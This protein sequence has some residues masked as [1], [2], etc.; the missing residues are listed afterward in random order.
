MIDFDKIV[1]SYWGTYVSYV[2][3]FIHDENIK[4]YT[5][6]F[7]VGCLGLFIVVKLLQKLYTQHII[8]RWDP[9]RLVE[10][11]CFFCHFYNKIPYVND[12]QWVCFQCQQYNGFDKS[13]GDYNAVSPLMYQAVQSSGTNGNRG[14]LSP[15]KYKPFSGNH[16]NGTQSEESTQLCSKCLFH[17]QL[18][19]KRL[20]EFEPTKDKDSEYK[21]FINQVEKEFQLCNECNEKTQAEINRKDRYIISSLLNNNSNTNS[22]SNSFIRNSNSSKNNNFIQK[23]LGQLFLSIDYPKLISFLNIIITFILIVLITTS[24]IKIGITIDNNSKDQES[25]TR[26]KNNNSDDKQDTLQH[27]EIISNLLF[28]ILNIQQNETIVLVTLFILKLFYMFYKYNQEILMFKTILKHPKGTISR[29]SIIFNLL[30]VF[31]LAQIQYPSINLQLF[32]LSNIWNHF[33]TNNVFTF[34]FYLMLLIIQR[35]DTGFKG[36]QAVFTNNIT[37]KSSNNESNNSNQNNNNNN[38]NSNNSNVI[39]HKEFF[40]SM[41][42][43]ESTSTSTSSPK[44]TPIKK[45]S[46]FQLS[47]LS[48]NEPVKELPS[49]DRLISSLQLDDEFNSNTTTNNNTTK[50]KTPTMVPSDSITQLLFF[51]IK[52]LLM[53]IFSMLKDI[54][55]FINRYRQFLFGF[56]VCL[57]FM[58]YNY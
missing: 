25:T 9:Y 57:I 47:D 18:K 56:F 42:L 24:I 35:M 32:Y 19:T 17:L 45:R 16:S 33:S 43:N 11:K 3:H 48:T 15:S 13:T 40:S 26:D 2:S 37:K 53:N 55:L 7:G 58:L 30:I 4:E 23:R 1:S 6:Y 22:N 36:P 52:S 5:V 50:T 41:M 34:M 27:N 44:T 49:M 14:Y 51:L 12:N 10:R 39:K 28:N 8:P 38:N 20:S 54:F 21:K 29:E 31:K 46:P